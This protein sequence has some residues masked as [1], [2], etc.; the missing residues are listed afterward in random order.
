M[1]RLRARV[2]NRRRRLTQ[3]YLDAALRW[4]DTE[5]PLRSAYISSLRSNERTL[6]CL[7]EARAAADVEQAPEP[8]D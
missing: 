5:S 1:A 4:E 8:Q 2:T 7:R 6:A 3:P